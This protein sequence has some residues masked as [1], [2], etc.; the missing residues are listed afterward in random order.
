MDTD[1]VIQAV[2][3]W[4]EA[5]QTGRRLYLMRSDPRQ[6]AHWAL[7]GGRVEAGESLLD[8]IH[9]EC[10]EEMGVNFVNAKFVPVEKFTAQD[11]NFV[12]HT[13]F[14][15]CDREFTP[16]LNHEHLGWAWVDQATWPK[17]LHTGLWTTMQIQAVRSKIAA[18]DAQDRVVNLVGQ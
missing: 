13:L 15:M 10:H 14:C 7:P 1:S 3:I 17:P 6:W 18:L 4:F 5:Q 2:G 9:R 16:V 11:G 8:A 12:Y